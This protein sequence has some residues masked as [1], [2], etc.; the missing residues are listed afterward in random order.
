MKKKDIPHTEKYLFD[1]ENDYVSACGRYLNRDESK[2]PIWLLSGKNGNLRALIVNSRSTVI[3]VLCGLEKLPELNF[4]RGFFRTKKIHSI[5]GSKK[6]VLIMENSVMNFG[7]KITDTIDYDFM[8]LNRKQ[9][10]ENKQQRIENREKIGINNLVLK[11]P[12]LVDLDAIAPLQAA[13]E[14]EEV[15]PNG[16]DFHAAA[17]RIN[18]ARIIADGKILAAEV[19]GKFIGKINV[20]SVSFTKY[21]IGGVYIHPD[22]RG[23]GIARA[24]ASVFI[25]SLLMNGKD[26][27]LFVKKSNNAARRLY[28]SLGFKIQ[29]DYR[30]T[31]F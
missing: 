12:R 28:A 21:L 27:T 9:R 8:I 1:I 16:S 24:M 22:F 26:T 19:D 10:T 4:L 13:Y 29:D 25:D 18:I 6:E 31:Y 5:Q 15:I 23:Q 30:I 7:W 14:K 11:K 20:S 17:S 3:P 2:D